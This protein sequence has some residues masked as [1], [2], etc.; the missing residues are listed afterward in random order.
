M[1]SSTSNL[2]SRKLLLL[3]SVF[4]LLLLP[5][6]AFAAP[7][8]KSDG[9]RIHITADRLVAGGKESYAEFIGNV[10]AVQEATVITAQRLRIHYAAGGKGAGKG[11]AARSIEKIEASGTVSIRMDGRQADSAEAV[12]TTADRVLVLTGENSRI[13]SGE[14]FITGS[15]IV[16]K[17]DGG[18]ITVEGGGKQRVEAV[19][20]SGDSGLE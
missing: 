14:N 10:K 17:R 20:H 1:N 5:G 11:P 15:R 4:W 8:E 3:F 16:M 7:E 13:S 19:I 2:L 6:M 12:Y 18:Q 9:G